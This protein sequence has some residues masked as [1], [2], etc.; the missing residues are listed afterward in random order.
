MEKSFCLR[1]DFLFIPVYL[2]NEEELVS[3]YCGESKIYEFKIP[4]GEAGFSY[5]ASVDAHDF[6]GK[7][8]TVTGGFS[9]D[10]FEK[11]TTAVEENVPEESHPLVHF[12]AKYGWINDP[13][14]LV[15]DGQNYHLYF[16]HNPFNIS[17]E[18]MSWGHAVSNDLLH[19]EQ[20][21]DVLFPDQ[22]GTMFSGCGMKVNNQLLFPYTVAG[23]SSPWSKGKPF[24]QGMAISTDGGENLHKQEGQFLGIVGKDSRDPKIFW[25]EDTNA[26]IMVLYLEGNDFGIFRSEDLK[27]WQQTQHF[28]IEK[29][30]E[31]P[32]LLCIPGPEGG[33]WM[34]W[35]S[36]GFYYWGDFDGYTFTSDFKRHEAYAGGRLYA[37]QTY[38]GTEGRIVAVPWLRFKERNGKYYQGA[39]GIPREYS[40]EKH[41]GDYRLIQ[42]PVREFTDA[43]ETADSIEEGK[44][45]DITLYR[46][47]VKECRL[48]CNESVI[49][50]DYVN[51]KIT[52]DDETIDYPCN[53]DELELILDH[54]IMEITVSNAI[55][56]AHKTK[57]SKTYGN[58]KGCSSQ[59]WTDCNYS[60]KSIK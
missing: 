4:M 54:N 9:E 3:F 56:S 48:T 59:E 36:D 57:G 8:I 17:W 24:Y 50:I 58:I 6:N 14:G 18:N 10:F 22:H 60:I 13:N 37:A 55:I 2:G 19:W 23:N 11:L 30:W 20:K 26:Y 53:I 16:Q 45:Y 12:T 25:H 1:N 32:D 46:N 34:F 40:Y 27:E 38:W 42:K 41:D 49:D 28:T 51:R 47:G 29:A 33:K 15:F 44:A 21:K 7:E 43:L 52:V 39:M 35:S 5:I 31:C